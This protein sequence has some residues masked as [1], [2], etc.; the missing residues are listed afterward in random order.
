MRILAAIVYCIL[1]KVCRFASDELVLW[2]QSFASAGEHLLSL[3]SS[4][5]VS[6]D[7]VI[8]S[9]ISF[10]EWLTKNVE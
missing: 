2:V 7:E 4:A 5:S 8:L 6:L 10:A 3:T 1:S 9:H